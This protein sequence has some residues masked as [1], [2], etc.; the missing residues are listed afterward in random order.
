MPAAFPS[1]GQ[2]APKIQAEARRSEALCRLDAAVPGDDPILLV[3]QYRV[4]ESELPDTPGDL[5]DLLLGVGTRVAR[6]IIIVLLW[7]RASEPRPDLSRLPTFDTGTIFFRSCRAISASLLTCRFSLQSKERMPAGKT[8]EIS[9]Q[10][11]RFPPFSS[12]EW[13]QFPD[14]NAVHG[15]IR[16]MQ[17]RDGFALECVL[18]HF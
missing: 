8:R 12:H 4:G 14:E 1:A 5:A 17:G 16:E 9:L 11:G 13:R 3:D 2:M 6:C 10:N 18:H 7:W 15:N